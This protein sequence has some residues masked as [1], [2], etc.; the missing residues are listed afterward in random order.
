MKKMITE[1]MQWSNVSYELENEKMKLF[2]YDDM[3]ISLIGNAENKKI[4]D[5]GCGPGIL[6]SIL[7]DSGATAGAF[8]ISPEMRKLCAE[9]IGH[10]NIYEYVED[11]PENYFDVAIC[12]L[13]LCIVDESEAEN[14]VSNIR[15]IISENGKAYIGFCNPLI[16]D[17]PESNLDFRLITGKNYEENHQYRKI[18]KEGNY[19]IIEMHRPIEWYLD[20]FRK[21][22]FNGIERFFTPEYILDGQKINDFVIFEISRK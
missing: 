8:D 14:I 13:V 4:I 3:L 22:G 9:K 17:V 12:N 11:I 19:E 21:S 5:Y 1:Q 15:R 20:I 6:I 16:F 2:S 7:R 10:E 18:K